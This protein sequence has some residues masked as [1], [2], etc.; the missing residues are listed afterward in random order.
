MDLDRTMLRMPLPKSSEIY[1]LVSY[2]TKED[3]LGDKG[4]FSKISEEM[5]NID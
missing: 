2:F 4:E 3:I 1:Y 5:E